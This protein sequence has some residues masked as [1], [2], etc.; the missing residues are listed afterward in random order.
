M[1]FEGAF[2]HPARIVA[3]GRKMTIDFYFDFLSPYAYLAHRHLFAIAERTDA[4]VVLKP[5][6]L[7]ALLNAHGHKGPAE[8]PPKREWVF[9]ETARRAVLHGIPM[10]VPHTHPFNPL[11]ALRAVHA[12]PRDKK[13][14]LCDGFWAEAW[15]GAAT[16]GLEHPDTIVRCADNAGLDGAALLAQIQTPALKSSFRAETATALERGVFGVPTYCVDDELFWGFDALDLLELHLQGEDPLPSNLM[17]QLDGL[18][19]SAI[20]R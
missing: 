13:R 20:R 16:Q 6:L 1:Y 7:A 10:G 3:K 4:T 19:P 8:I 15:G 17:A 9:K 2:E 18:E 5:T 14:A 11:M 12:C